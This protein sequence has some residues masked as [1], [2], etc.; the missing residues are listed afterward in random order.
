[1]ENHS[2]KT[3]Q[4]TIF[5]LNKHSKTFDYNVIIAH[6]PGC[7]APE[8]P[9]HFVSNNKSTF[10]YKKPAIQVCVNDK[11]I[12]KQYFC[13]YPDDCCQIDFV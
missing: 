5:F 11:S 12:V 13:V 8:E 9:I 4:A 10:T 6:T 2:F 7:G 3:V 1:M